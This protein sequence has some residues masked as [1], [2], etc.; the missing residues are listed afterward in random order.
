MLIITAVQFRLCRWCRD[1]DVVLRRRGRLTCVGRKL[2]GD[3]KYRTH[4]IS[5][6]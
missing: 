6:E 3:S 5:S 1:V 4:S 2:G